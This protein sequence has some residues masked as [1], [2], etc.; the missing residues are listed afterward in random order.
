MELVRVRAAM[1]AAGA[2]RNS[3]AALLPPIVSN[4]CVS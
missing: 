3:G 1:L 2:R 4:A